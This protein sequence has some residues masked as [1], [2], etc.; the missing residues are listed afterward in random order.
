MDG[1][2]G[3]LVAVFVGSVAGVVLVFGLYPLAVL[4]AGWLRPERPPAAAASTPSVSLL[5]AVRNGEALVGEKVRNSLALRHASERQAVFV[6][7]GSTDRTVECL[8]AEARPG[9][10]VLEI[11]EHHG[12]AHALNAGAERC[13]GE[14]LVFSDADALLPPD[15]LEWLL[16]PFADPSVGGVCGQRVIHDGD[17]NGL[18]AAQGSYIAADSGLKR[19]ESRLGSVTSNDGKLYAIRRELF[20]PIAAGATDDL[21]AC[22]TV[23][24]QGRRFVFEPRARA[25]IRTPSRDAGHELARRRRIVARSLHGIAAKRALLNPFRHGAFA[26]QLLINK[27]CR[28]LLPLFLIGLF[29]SSLALSFRPGHWVA[30]L[31]LAGQLALLLLALAQ[32]ALVR[33]PG[34]GKAAATARYFWVG[35][36]G[37]LLGL[38]DFARGREAVKWEPRKSG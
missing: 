17:G 24:E 18:S 23:V 7:D 28:R 19:A 37:T 3:L 27:V 4:C 1:L 9:V 32:P 34:L 33:V 36:L 38:A 13:R 35:I 22:L 31:A 15:A 10:E 20:R 25:L 5:V 14:I 26:F 6:S 29:V 16:A 12:K 8:R 21:Y 30:R 2:E 11:V